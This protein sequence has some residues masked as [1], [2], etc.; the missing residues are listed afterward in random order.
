[1]YQ[2]IK[3]FIVGLL[4]GLVGTTAMAAP[5]SGFLDDYSGLK[6]DADRPGA[7]IYRK[8]DV[9]LGTYDKVVIS[10]I[11]IWYHPDTE[12]KGIDPDE[13]KVLADT[14]RQTIITEL[15]PDYP[16]INTTG[17]GVLVLR[18]AITNVKMKKK[19]RSLLGYMPIG[20]AVTTLQDMAGK[21]IQLADATIE[22]ELLDGETGER[23]A[24]LVD[25]VSKNLD[26]DAEPS[27]ESLNSALTFYAKRLRTRLDEVR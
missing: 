1:M 3:R 19:E 15:E 22:A 14:F 24:L 21:R 17:K 20:F 18:L 6:P 4:L 8:P 5:Q 12:Y 7:M 23:L 9:K 16:V 10:T 11:E 13:M 26:D 2:I 25:D 27:W